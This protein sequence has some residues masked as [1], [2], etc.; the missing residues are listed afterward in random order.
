MRFTIR[1]T[2]AQARALTL[3][4]LVNSRFCPQQW[5]LLNEMDEDQIWAL[6]DSSTTRERQAVLGSGPLSDEL[7]MMLPLPT[8]DE[9]LR[10]IMYIDWVMRAELR[11]AYNG[12]GQALVGGGTRLVTYERARRHAD[13][14][15]AQKC[16][17]GVH[18]LD[19]AL[20]QDATMHLRVALT[21]PEG[22]T[23]DLG[24]LCE[25]IS[26]D[27]LNTIDPLAPLKRSIFNGIDAHN[28]EMIPACRE[29]VPPSRREIS[30]TG[31]NGS[32]PFRQ[33]TGQLG[34]SI[35]GWGF[36]I[37]TDEEIAAIRAGKL[38]SKLDAL[39]QSGGQC[40]LCDKVLDPS[41]FTGQSYAHL[42]G[43]KL[44]Q[45]PGPFVDDPCHHWLN[46]QTA[47]YKANATLQELRK[48]RAVSMAY[49]TV[50]RWNAQ[51]CCAICL[52]TD[53]GRAR[54]NTL[55]M[56]AAEYVG[57]VCCALCYS[58]MR[59]ARKSTT[60]DLSTAEGERAWVAHRRAFVAAKEAKAEEL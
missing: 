52:S 22:T 35:W 48:A 11:Y 12:V 27:F 30:F 18:H 4:Q 16:S 14:G 34:G 19:V 5:R 50:D 31:L 58:G 55:L 37:L 40:G 39:A 24:V 60:F 41:L 51:G 3:D 9:L 38:Q 49:T 32:S 53:Y 42:Y 23:Q 17:E 44:A 45:I 57:T 20:H 47:E 54:Q 36:A 15:L 33:G 26:S 2:I 7:I 56:H 46:K 8:A 1:T 6:I 21:F 13:E 28:P 43:N 25:G 10:S 59:N 29:A